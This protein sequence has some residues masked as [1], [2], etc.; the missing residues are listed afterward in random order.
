MTIGHEAVL[1]AEEREAKEST[2]I[3]VSPGLFVVLRSTAFIAGKLGT[4]YA[5]PMTFLTVGYAGTMA[6]F[7][8]MALLTKVPWPR[9]WTA[10]G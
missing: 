5:P 2:W 4:P 10:E 8:V 3:A 7:L 9:T 6:I 1:Y